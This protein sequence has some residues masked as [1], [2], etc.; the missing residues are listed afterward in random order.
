M[1]LTASI[2]G[3]F[4]LPSPLNVILFGL[5]VIF[6]VAEIFLWMRF[7]ERYRVRGG[8]E[9]MPGERAIVLQACDPDGMV[10]VRGE[11]WSAKAAGEAL[12]EGARATVL[13]VDGLTVTV[14]REAR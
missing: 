12:E 9:G 6:E 7:L 8:V 4:V 11:V 13:S 10:R 5:A 1:V 14:G 2:V 3:L